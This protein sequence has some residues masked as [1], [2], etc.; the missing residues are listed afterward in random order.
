MEY[1]QAIQ[2]LETIISSMDS[3][4]KDFWKNYSGMMVSVGRVFGGDAVKRF[5]AEDVRSLI[6]EIEAVMPMEFE[7]GE[8]V[9]R[10]KECVVKDLMERGVLKQDNTICPF[11]RGFI[12]KVF[13][14]VGVKAIC[15]DCEVKIL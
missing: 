3:A 1:E 11:I 14:S 15:K 5:L 7:I 10:V 4:I 9:I 12:S 2:S 6:K 8:N 13:E